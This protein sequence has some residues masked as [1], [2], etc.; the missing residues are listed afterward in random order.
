MGELK[1]VKQHLL[2]RAEKY[3]KMAEIIRQNVKV[4]K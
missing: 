2:E 1:S 4:D 3:E